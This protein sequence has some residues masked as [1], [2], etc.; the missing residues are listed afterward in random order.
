MSAACALAGVY[1][2]ILHPTPC[3]LELCASAHS[4]LP[5]NVRPRLMVGQGM[6]S[7]EL[8]ANPALH[9]NFVQVKGSSFIDLAY[10]PPS[11]DS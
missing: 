9:Q 8:G 3:V 6:N 7:V 4:H 1:A 5:P 2:Q 11:T 10:N